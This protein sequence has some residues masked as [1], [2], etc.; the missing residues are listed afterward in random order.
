MTKEHSQKDN[1]DR[2]STV[3]PSDFM[4]ARHPELFPDTEEASQSELS[5][6]LL[7]YHLDSL[8]SRKQEL[9]FEDF[10][11]RLSER[12]ICPNIVP[13]TGPIGGGDSKADATTYPVSVHLAFRTYFG[14]PEPPAA[15]KWSFAFSCKR[16]WK[17]K[18]KNDITEIAKHYSEVEKIF[19]IS[20]QF[21]R[22]KVRSSFELE[23]QESTGKDITLLDRNWIVTRILEY[24]NEDLAESILGVRSVSKKPPEPSPRDYERTKN[25]ESLLKDLSRTEEYHG[26][27][28]AIAQDYLSAALLARDLGK[29]RHEIDGLFSRAI[30]IAENL[31]NLHQILSCRYQHAWTTLWWFDS[32]ADFLSQVKNMISKIEKIVDA[33][34]CELFCNLFSVSI[35]A[36][37]S[38]KLKEEDR[39]LNDFY[40]SISDRLSAIAEDKRRPNNSLL[41]RTNLAFLRLSFATIVQNVQPNMF[42]DIEDCIKQSQG[43]STYPVISIIDNLVDLGEVLSKYEGYEELL[44]SICSITKKRRGETA[45]GRLLLRRAEAIDITS[46]PRKALLLFGKARTR[47][48]KSETLTD[49]FSSSMGCCDAYLSLGYYWAAKMEALC[50]AHFSLGT[51]SK[52]HKYCRESFLTTKRLSWIELQT[53]RIRQF[54]RWRPLVESLMVNLKAQKYNTSKFENE[55][56]YQDAMLSCFLLN[57]KKAAV[58]EAKWLHK[59]VDVRRLPLSFSTLEYIS[60]NP[61]AHKYFPRG[62]EDASNDFFEIMRNQPARLDM[63]SFTS[64]NLGSSQTMETQLLDVNIRIRV[65]GNF[66]TI[67]FAENLLGIMEAA[68]SLAEL[69]NFAIVVDELEIVVG[70]SSHGNTPPEIEKPRIAGSNTY[71]IIWGLDLQE[72]LID[73]DRDDV[74]NY[75]LALLVSIISEITVDPIGDI[76]QQ[77]E[78]WYK[79]DTLNR[80]LGTTPTIIALKDLLGDYNSG[81]E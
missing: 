73:T 38:L 75:F 42:G 76:M 77:L 49:G 45:E 70:S 60:G 11:R 35:A 71:H 47:L 52:V 54:L 39:F 13:Q 40:K 32:F 46:S 78:S 64:F 79:Q 19:F 8:T 30:S 55:M 69:E 74:A 12:T 31:G 10:C 20:N 50:V 43:L 5:Q 41:A 59:A 17:S 27:D 28:F 24:H 14:T 29:A 25:L 34:D 65:D 36:V 51:T 4:R 80:A 67:V 1:S 18:A 15:G 56:S 16:K 44:D 61:D 21:I 2:L 22:D 66:S 23:L 58:L 72:W 7:E 63:P 37:N 6:D 62:F 3:K 9:L 81:T 57:C 53:G 68:L 33:E 48:Y 26:N